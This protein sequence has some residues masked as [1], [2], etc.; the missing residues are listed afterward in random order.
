MA[1]IAK[2]TVNHNGL[3]FAPGQAVD[4]TGADKA[5]L[6][7]LDA[8]EEQDFAAADKET[9]ASRAEL[10]RELAEKSAKEAADAALAVKAAADTAAAA[11]KVS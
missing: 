1:L 7:A 6:L 11:T 4:A 3:T 2:N 5:R 10:N 8:V 9:K